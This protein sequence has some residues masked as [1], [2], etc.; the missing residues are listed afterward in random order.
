MIL[1]VKILYVMGVLLGNMFIISFKMEILVYVWSYQRYC[2][3]F[4]SYLIY[5]QSDFQLYIYFCCELI[6]YK[7][8]IFYMVNIEKYKLLL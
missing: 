4:I 8:N 7:L 6:C 1:G 5:F 3:N 2:I